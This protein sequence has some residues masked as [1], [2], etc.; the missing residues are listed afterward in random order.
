MEIQWS[1]VIFTALSGTAGWLLAAVAYAEFAG[2]LKKSVFPATLTALVL[3]IVGGLASVTHLSHPERMLEALN[4]PTSGIFIEAVLLGITAALAIVL[5]VLIK[6]EASP[7]ARKV[8][9]VLAAVVGVALSYEAGASYMMEAHANWN[10]MLLPLG[11]LATAIPAGISLFI[12]IA[13]FCDEE[14][15]LGVLPVA[16]IAGGVIAAVVAAI[17]TVSKGGPD[18]LLLGWILSV[19]VGGVLPAVFGVILA[20]KPS[21]ARAVAAVVVVCALVG[22]I[23]FR[24]DMWTAAQF[25]H[26][27]FSPL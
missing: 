23:A 1:L 26:N 11:Y 3:L 2:G 21:T 12:L 24:A 27:F 19:C 20:K 16:L 22:A 13:G 18:A 5:M 4:H 7:T 25:V 9:A 6:R 14:D 8:I 15:Q 10:T 17:G